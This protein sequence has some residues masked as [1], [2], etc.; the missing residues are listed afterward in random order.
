MHA[1]RL[2]RWYGID[3]TTGAATRLPK[4]DPR[5]EKLHA[6]TVNERL[7]ESI[8]ALNPELIGVE[9]HRPLALHGMQSS[10]DQVYTDAH[11]RLV[12][13]EFK[14]SARRDAALQLLGYGHHIG[15]G[16]PF[17]ETDV[18]H[19]GVDV[20]NVTRPDLRGDATH[21]F[22]LES[23][24]SISTALERL[25]AKLGKAP[26][27]EEL[28]RIARQRLGL[29]ADG[30]IVPT[31]FPLLAAPRMVLVAGRVTEDCADFVAELQKQ[32]IDVRSIQ[33][34]LF[35][36]RKGEILS[37]EVLSNVEAME[38]LHS[39]LGDLWPKI[40]KYYVPDGWY[41][42]RKGVACFSFVGREQA[43]MTFNMSVDP[44]RTLKVEMRI[45]H[46]TFDKKT[47]RRLRDALEEK[48]PS[49]ASRS[50][51]DW[52]WSYPPASL[53]AWLRTAAEVASALRAVFMTAKDTK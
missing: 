10:A 47:T 12:V 15:F 16:A 29:E 34:Q 17:E 31:M 6:V 26:T 35:E 53:S 38:V 8:V 42:S 51:S 20:I 50:G 14:V 39:A 30:V 21:F 32:W 46:A 1:E 23:H 43:S 11:G 41:A 4:F 9:N 27:V 22:S 37:V 13:V 5:S 3:G 28:G 18:R 36:C 48:L 7:L 44:E 40:S 45:P 52:I 2:T 33:L 19:I 25:Q 49:G 24:D